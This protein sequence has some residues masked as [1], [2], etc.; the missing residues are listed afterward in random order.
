MPVHCNVLCA[1]REEALQMPRGD[2]QLSFCSSCGFIQNIAFDPERMRYSATYENSLHFSP[3]FQKYA[4]ELAARLVDR[5]ELRRKRIIEIACGRGD[6]L[7]ALCRLGD[8]RGTGFDPSYTPEAAA[9][10]PDDRVTIV[11]DF[12]SDRHAEYAADFVCCRQALEHLFDP[13][14]FLRMVRR[15]LG[16]RSRTLVFFE[17]PNALFTLRELGIWDLIY[18]HCTYFVPG[19][20]R[21]CFER[22]SFEVLEV[23]E[24]FGGQ[25]L[26]VAAKPADG[27]VAQTGDEKQVRLSQEVRAFA[28]NYRSKVET[29]RS[30]IDALR[31]SG[32]A[33]VWGAGSKGVTFLN[34]L[35][36][37]D[38]I[39]H[40]VD[41]NPRKQG[42]YVAGAGQKV[43]P[44]ILLQEYQPDTVIV[45]N[46]LYAHEIGDTLCRMDIR[47]DLLTA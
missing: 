35:P 38:V 42:M 10:D 17:V 19:S 22:S 43:V 40:V 4:D 34:I 20:L 37:E 3:R 33:V 31:P 9:E 6:F 16:E 41:V 8:N 27:A 36:A 13:L 28:A 47:A 25:F 7:R 39:K 29:W 5:Y 11:P 14:A 30:R 23:G 46:P 26:C 18:E 2:I 12:Y 21:R 44:P 32:R 1:T 24:E 15:N 45:M